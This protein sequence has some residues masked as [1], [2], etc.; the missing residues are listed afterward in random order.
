MLERHLTLSTAPKAA[1]AY[2]RETDLK[3]HSWALMSSLLQ[4]V[5]RVY[6]GRHEAGHLLPITL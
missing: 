3:L 6:P 4:D 5:E 2:S 1:E